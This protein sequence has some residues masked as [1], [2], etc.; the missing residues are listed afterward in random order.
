MSSMIARAS[1]NT[2]TEA[3]TERPSKASTPTAKAM[4]VA[5]GTAQPWRTPSALL[6]ARY[7][8]AGTITPPKA[9]TIGKAASLRLASAPS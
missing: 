1:R 7:N 5:V 9:A 3:G 4:S 6:N 2:R 8:S